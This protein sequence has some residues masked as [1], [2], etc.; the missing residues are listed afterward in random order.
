MKPIPNPFPWRSCF[1]C[2]DRNPVGLKLTF[3]ETGTEPRELVCR[4]AVP[5]VYSGFGKIVH[6]GFQMGLFDEIMGWAV[7]HLVRQVGLTAS[8]QVKFRSPLF[9]GQTIEVRCRIESKDGPRITLGS[10]IRNEA[11]IVCTTA[12]GV[13]VL[14]E[15]ERYEQMVGE[16]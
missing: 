1:F 16:D 15:A 3:Q 11:G 4:W 5:E 9:V 13:Y 12:T 2:G 7:Q 10:E 14:M 8:L 6:G